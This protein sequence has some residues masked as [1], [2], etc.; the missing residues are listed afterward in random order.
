MRVLVLCRCCVSMVRTPV[1]HQ[2]RPGLF[3][4][5]CTVMC[6]RSWLVLFFFAL[7]FLP[8]PIATLSIFNL[9]CTNQGYQLPTSSN[10]ENWQRRDNTR[11]RHNARNMTSF[12]QKN[13]RQ[14]CCWNCNICT[15]LVYFPPIT[16][17]LILQWHTKVA[18]ET[19]NVKI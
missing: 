2:H 16:L 4:G 5:V 7:R 11:W 9:E 13:M 14:R 6:F 12:V 3:S 18:E 1:T 19:F 17:L 10:I 8:L 15:W